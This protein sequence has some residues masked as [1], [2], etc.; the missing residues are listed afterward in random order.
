[1]PYVHLTRDDVVRILEQLMNDSYPQEHWCCGIHY[2]E[3]KHKPQLERAEALRVAL[4]CYKTNS[5]PADEHT[6]SWHADHGMPI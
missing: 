1:M 4:E 6:S 2:D 5:R 3:A